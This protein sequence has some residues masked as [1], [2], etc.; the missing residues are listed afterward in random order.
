MGEVGYNRNEFLH[1]L[2]WWE[3]KAIIDGYRKRERTYLLMTRWSTYMIMST[4][5]AD[6]RKAGIT[7][8]QDLM[9][10]SWEND[11][12]RHTMFTPDELEEIDKM[13]NPKKG[14]GK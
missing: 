4:G 13:L 11:E 6:L 3:I 8:A 10:F 5:M 1:E 9:E 12:K 14:D 7:S 2:R